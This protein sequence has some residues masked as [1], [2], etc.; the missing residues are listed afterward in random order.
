M[1]TMLTG[2]FVAITM[3]TAPKIPASVMEA[4]STNTPPVVARKIAKCDFDGDE[5][6]FVYRATGYE[7]SWVVFDAA[8]R[9]IGDRILPET[10]PASGMVDLS[11]LTSCQ[12]LRSED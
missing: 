5:A 6:F 7:Q 12:L 10:G 2:A 4:Y 8:G 11:A 9:Q 3:S 1:L